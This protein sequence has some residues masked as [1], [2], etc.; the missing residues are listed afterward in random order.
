MGWRS[1][2]S[3]SSRQRGQPSGPLLEEVSVHLDEAGSLALARE[4]STVGSGIVLAVGGL[5][6]KQHLHGLGAGDR[7]V[8]VEEQHRPRGHPSPPEPPIPMTN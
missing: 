6:G 7:E 5:T 3:G 4:Q 1:Q 2:V 8:R